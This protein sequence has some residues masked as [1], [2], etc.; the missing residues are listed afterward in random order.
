M[1]QEDT[2]AAGFG[3]AIASL[4]VPGGPLAWVSDEHVAFRPMTP[5]SSSSRFVLPGNDELAK[6]VSLLPVPIQPIPDPKLSRLSSQRWASCSVRQGLLGRVL[7]G[8]APAPGRPLR[9]RG[10]GLGRAPPQLH[11]HGPGPP[12]K[13]VPFLPCFRRCHSDFSGRIINWNT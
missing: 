1:T 11:L 6:E 3:S 8:E 4:C 2:F 7:T 13:Y 10:P 9:V 5:S 12:K